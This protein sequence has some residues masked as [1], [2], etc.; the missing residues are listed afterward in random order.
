M[1]KALIGMLGLAVI[2]G[3]LLIDHHAT[4]ASDHEADFVTDTQADI[5]DLYAWM[6]PAGNKLNLVMTV[7][8]ANFSDSLQYVFHVNSSAGF[9]MTQT[10]TL[11]LCHFDANQNASCWVGKAGETGGGSDYQAFVSGDASDPT[12]PL[13]TDDNNLQVFAGSRNDPFYFNQ[14]GFAR[15][16]QDIRNSGALTYDANSCP[17]N[18]ANAADFVNQLAQKDEG[19]A[20][21]QNPNSAED[22][23]AGRNVSALVVQVDKT[24]IA[25]GGAIL[26]VWAST[27][28]R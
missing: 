4:N 14:S 8:G 25:S 1:R 12:V 15:V 22:E 17:N 27:R 28:M 13:K 20:L 9:G 16:V 7:P 19:G 18:V 6:Q 10:E 26:G 2:M 3:L 21:G 11:I 5:A 24:L 23:L